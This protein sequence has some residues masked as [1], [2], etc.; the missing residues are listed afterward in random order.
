M[1]ARGGNVLTGTWSTRVTDRGALLKLE[2][3]TLVDFTF[4]WIVYDIEDG[5]IKLFEVGDNRIIMK[6]NCDVVI[7]VTKERIKNY[8]QECLWRIT[9]LSV[10]G[11]DNEK[12]Y[13]GTPLKFYENDVVKLRVNGEL[14]EG[15]YEIG[16]R[17]A[18]AIL[19]I[20]LEG[21]PNLKLEWLI[22]FLEPGLIKLEN[23]S[24]RMILERH[25]PDANEDLIVVDR[26]LING[27]WEV[28]KY[29]DGLVHVIDPTEN[30]NTYTLN[31]LA[32]G[33]ILVTDPNNGVT[34]GSWLAYRNDGLFLGMH[35]KD[36]A[37]F[38]ELNH[39]WRIKEILP[40]KIELKALSPS[41]EIERLLVLE[42]KA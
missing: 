31:F 18:G 17:N 35:F 8:L 14:V 34:A 21:R 6:K 23:A 26:I 2:F 22:S 28:T 37:P 12:D 10:D 11:V 38:N 1:R 7:D 4:E 16:L 24:N 25:C 9:R 32:R 15:T 29:D 42:K 30:F 39:R 33:R 5:K 40:N 19:K 36:Q 41:G 3:E 20:N 13:I 27:E